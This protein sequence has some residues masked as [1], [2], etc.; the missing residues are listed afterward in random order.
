MNEH[1]PSRAVVELT[2]CYRLGQNPYVPHHTA[3]GV[4]VAPGGRTALREVLEAMGAVRYQAYLWPR[5]DE[6]SATRPPEGWKRPY[7]LG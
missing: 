5:P 4:Y 1:E 2:T 3:F 7:G 6:F